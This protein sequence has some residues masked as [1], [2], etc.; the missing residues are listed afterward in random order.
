MAFSPG[1][2]ILTSGTEHFNRSG[3]YMDVDAPKMFSLQ[4]LEGTT[5]GLKDTH[6]TLLSASTAKVVFGN[7]PAMG[8]RI[9]I[10]NHLPVKVT[11]V[12]PDLPYNTTLR[13]IGFIAPWHLYITT[14]DWIL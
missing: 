4:M 10:G 14:A 12:Y 1:I 9:T 5:D 6:S 13:D 7:K 11:G 2:S 8:S 3:T